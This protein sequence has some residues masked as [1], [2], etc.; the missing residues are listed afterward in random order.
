M[1]TPVSYRQTHSP[2]NVPTA[3]TGLLLGFQLFLLFWPLPLQ[4]YILDIW[5]TK[6]IQI[7][8]S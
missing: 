7:A 2:M 3:L 8:V 5:S 1:V 6:Q 4:V